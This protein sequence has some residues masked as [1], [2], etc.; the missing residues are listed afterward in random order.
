M[1][2]DEREAFMDADWSDDDFDEILTEMF[3]GFVAFCLI[4]FAIAWWLS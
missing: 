3:A 2:P 4:M 1:T